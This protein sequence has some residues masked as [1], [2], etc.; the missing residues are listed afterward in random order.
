MPQS[1][2]RKSAGIA[3]RIPPRT[4]QNIFRTAVDHLGN[5]KNAMPGSSA[6]PLQFT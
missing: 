5:D 3:K 4:L 2:K 6:V 1:I